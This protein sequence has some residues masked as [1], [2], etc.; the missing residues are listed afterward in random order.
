MTFLHLFSLV[1]LKCV[2]QP[3]YLVAVNEN[4]GSKFLH[5]FG[6]LYGLTLKILAIDIILII[7]D[8]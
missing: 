8:I 2:E 1:E 7:V 3:I 4:V 6:C 5:R